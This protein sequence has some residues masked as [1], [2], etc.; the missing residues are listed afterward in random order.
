MITVK[1]KL[2]KTGQTVYYNGSPHTVS[3]VIL[4]GYDIFLQLDNIW[5]RVNAEY[6][7]CEF[8]E[9]SLLR[10]NGV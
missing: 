9:I 6:V 2:F 8:T 1:L 5:Q 7:E 10:N 4:V 3:H